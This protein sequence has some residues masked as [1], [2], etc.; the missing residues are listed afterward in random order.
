MLGRREFIQAAGSAMFQ[1]GASR[2]NFVVIVSDDQGMGDLGCYGAKDVKTPNLDRLAAA[3]VRFTDWHANSPVCSPSRASLLTGCYPQRTGIPQIL[4]SKP[5]FD[6]PGLRAGQPTLP[7]ELRKLGY[8][9]AAIGKWHLGSTPE[10]RPLAQ[11]FDEFFGYYSGWIDY[12]SHRFF[13]LGG[14]PVYHDLWRN[15]KEIWR[16]SEYMTEVLGG[17][18]QAFLKRQSKDQPFLL[19]LAFGAPHYPMMAPERYLDRFPDTMD[20][21][22]RMHCAMISAMD[23]AIGSVLATLTARGLDN[24]VVFFMSD[25]GATEEVRADHRG[26]TYHGGSNGVYR[27]S[28]GS[29]FEGGIHVPAMI[30]WPGVIAKGEVRKEC[31]VAMDVLPTFLE[32]AGAKSPPQVDGVSLGP[33]L[34]G[35]AP[36]PQRDLFWAYDDQFAL[37]RGPWKLLQNHRER[38]GDDLNKETWLSN[39]DS[40]A[41]EKRNLA[42]RSDTPAADMLK[43]LE[44]WRQLL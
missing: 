35:A 37:R 28:K 38:L 26:R 14:Q 15:E 3:G 16:D 8:R 42:E 12:Y 4:F 2:P 44:K 9:S 36:W 25:N 39:L 19:Y 22:R 31:G 7:S 5:N 33:T 21:D 27:G 1:R 23:D 11:G 34:R 24:T 17:E 20:R 43:S 30:S 40:D 10:S 6:V 41:G 29:L 18:A 13:T 32:W